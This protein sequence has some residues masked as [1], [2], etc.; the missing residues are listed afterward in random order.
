MK[1]P[2]LLY[3]L[4][5]VLLFSNIY[6]Y[7]AFKK[8]VRVLLSMTEE[9]NL[10]YTKQMAKKESIIYAMQEA[11]D[12]QLQYEGYALEPN[13]ILNDE[14]HETYY[15]KDIIQENHLIVRLRDTDCQ[16]CVNALMTILQKQKESRIA[17][18]ID[19]DN[20]RFLHD[21][22]EYH[23]QSQFYRVE[24]LPMQID[25]L[26]VPYL[27]VLDKELKIN[28]LFIPSIEKLNQ[29]V[30]YLENKSKVL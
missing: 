19:Y 12:M 20:E 28:H 9:L 26:N 1:Q 8:E 18:L 27:F 10:S 25:S 16:P 5:A 13:I 23:P 2:L 11:I 21:M 17:F 3:I 30:R 15:L 14:N 6:Q 4:L 24:S 29:T 22:K 7:L